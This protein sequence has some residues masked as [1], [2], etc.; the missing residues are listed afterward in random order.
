MRHFKGVLS[1]FTKNSTWVAI[2]PLSTAFLCVLGG[3]LDYALILTIVVFVAAIQLLRKRYIIYPQKRD[4]LAVLMLVNKTRSKS[5]EFRKNPDENFWVLR[6]TAFEII[7][8]EA[9]VE[10]YN[11]LVDDRTHTWE[12]QKQAVLG[13]TDTPSTTIFEQYPLS[14]TAA[15]NLFYKLASIQ[16]NPINEHSIYN[17]KTLVL[18]LE[19]ANEFD[20][21]IRQYRLYQ[22]ARK[23]LEFFGII[24]YK[25]RA[26]DENKGNLNGATVKIEK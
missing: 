7:G 8:K 24:A 12:Y 18:L 17:A 5:V 1:I 22:Y 25:R 4:A 13:I 6:L 10:Q 2:L 14:F 15:I 26:A 21:C 19:Q 3:I 11:G 23:V 9:V 16:N 20:S